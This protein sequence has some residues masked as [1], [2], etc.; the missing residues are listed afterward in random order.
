MNEL[1]L[2]TDEVLNKFKQLETKEQ[3][4][5]FKGA[6]RTA[7]NVLVKQARVN[8]KMVVQSSNKVTVKGK[9]KG[10]KL[11]SGIKTKVW[12][13]GKTAKVNILSDGRL[14]WFELGTNNRQ[15]KKQTKRKTHNTGSIKA[16]NFFSKAR[17]S[18]EDQVFNSLETIIMKQIEKVWN[19][20]QNIKQ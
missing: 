9:F 10:L 4:K 5:T 3:K 16:S 7:S 1:K 12:K 2:N 13:D 8:L 18:T 15:T 6:L 20:K 14:K 17:T 11:S 19:K